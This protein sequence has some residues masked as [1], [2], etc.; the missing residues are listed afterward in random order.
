MKTAFVI[1][2]RLESSRVPGKAL[3]PINGVPVLVHLM[4]RLKQTGIPIILAIP[5]AQRHIYETEI[6]EHFNGTVSYS[7]GFEDDPLARMSHTAEQYGLDNVIR[8]THDKIFVQPKVVSEFL[9]VYLKK[10]LDYVYSSKFT[11]G[12]AFEIISA[13]ALAEA[14]SKNKNVEFISY[15]VRGVT[16]NIL[17]YTGSVSRERSDLRLLIDYPDDVKLLETIFAT[18]GNDCTFDDVCK[19]ID[20]NPWALKINQLPK[21]TLY[22]CAFNAEKFIERCMGSVSKQRSFKNYEYIIIDDHS[23]DDTPR[24]VSK[25]CSLYPNTRWIRNSKNIGLASSSNVALKEA[26]GKYIMRLD[27][28]DYFPRADAVE[29]M[30]SEIE[31]TGKD[32]IVPNNYFGSVSK[33]QKGKDGMHVGGSIF[34]TRTIN[35]LRFTDGLRGYE[36]LDLFTRGRDVLNVG[37]LNKPIFFYHQREDSMSKTNLAEREEL[38]KKILSGTLSA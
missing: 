38:R 20:E 10:D 30:I 37:Y 6:T 19:F 3:K 15:A 7:H 34:R 1:C 31:S 24:L 4:N 35:F 16:D 26:R 33:I 21:L 13:K 28:D 12:T 17:D 11:D 25:F 23:S 8:V 32:V 2:S 5:K 36:G 27:A 18:L 14:A 22:T 29:Q 9:D